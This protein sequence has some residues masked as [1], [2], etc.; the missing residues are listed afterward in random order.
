MQRRPSAGAWRH[1]SRRWARSISTWPRRCWVSA[2]AACT[3]CSWHRIKSGVTL[4]H[5]CT[6]LGSALVVRR[7]PDQARPLLQRA[8]ALLRQAL[9]PDHPVTHAAIAAQM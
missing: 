1:A 3:G 5:A 2:S 4:G 8:L 7:E 6:G 9:G